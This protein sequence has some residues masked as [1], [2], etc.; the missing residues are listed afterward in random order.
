MIGRRGNKHPVMI[1]RRGNK[2]PV[3]IGRR[4]NK[5]LDFISIPLFGTIVGCSVNQQEGTTGGDSHTCSH[6]QTQ[7][8][9]SPPLPSSQSDKIENNTFIALYLST[10]V[11]C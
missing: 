5:H 8:K 10:G 1:G 6:N 2:H 4:G 3:M 9:V 11:E 7:K